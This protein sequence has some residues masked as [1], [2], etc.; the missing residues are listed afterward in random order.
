M[1]TLLFYNWLNLMTWSCPASIL[2]HLLFIITVWPHGKPLLVISTGCHLR[3]AK[4]SKD[5]YKLHSVVNT[6]IVMPN[7]LYPLTLIQPS[8][9]ISVPP[10]WSQIA[11]N[12]PVSA[13]L[14]GGGEHGEFVMFITK[15][16]SSK[17]FS[18]FK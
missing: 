7:V 17:Q 15:V 1:Y 5:I 18:L 14:H 11:F 6:G 4:V 3:N 13:S 12:H 9:I 8:V 16:F 10:L 2:F